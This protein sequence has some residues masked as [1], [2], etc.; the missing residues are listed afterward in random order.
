MIYYADSRDLKGRGPE[1]TEEKFP[2]S[3]AK[4]VEIQRTV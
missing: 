4:N 2:H 3:P 1:I